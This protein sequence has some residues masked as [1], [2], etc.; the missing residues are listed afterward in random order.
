M[1]CMVRSVITKRVLRTGALIHPIHDHAVHVVS[2]VGDEAENL[3]CAVTYT[4]GPRRIDRAVGTCRCSER[5]LVDRERD[6]DRVIRGIVCKRV[7]RRWSLG[8]T[9]NN[10]TVNMEAGVGSE[11]ENSASTVS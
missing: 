3:A 5:V 8:R 9:M 4:N 2:R 6:P 11:A 1:Y 7:L 10:Y